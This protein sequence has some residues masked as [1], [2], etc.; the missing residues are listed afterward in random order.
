MNSLK[1]NIVIALLVLAI[2][3][4]QL[5]LYVEVKQLR[6]D[7]QGSDNYLS[8]KIDDLD[9]DIYE[10]QDIIRNINVTD[11]GRGM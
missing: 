1:N 2:L 6:I 5:L 9:S 3:I 11:T 10:L 4:F 7:A 8:Q